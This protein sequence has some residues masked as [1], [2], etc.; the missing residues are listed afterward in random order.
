MMTIAKIGKFLR[1]LRSGTDKLAGNDAR[2]ATRATIE[3]HSPDFASGTVMPARYRG[4][5]GIFPP[6]LWSGVPHATKELVLIVED[7]DVPFPAPL[8]HAIAYGI[9]PSKSG[10]VAGEIPKL[11]IDNP[12]EIQGARLGKGAGLAPGFV[13]VTPIPGH[14]P[15]RYVFQVFALDVDL[16]P[17]ERP[18]SKSELLVAMAGHVIAR[19]ATVGLA[20]A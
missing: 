11:G 4:F 5:T 10:F 20:E 1:P 8:V 14:G 18:P 13:P 9:A 3:V 6:V 19:G 17:F 7:V 2:L 12:K 15:H 16:T